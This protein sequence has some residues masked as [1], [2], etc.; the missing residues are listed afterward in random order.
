M[1]RR[2]E[3]IE[4]DR[5]ASGLIRAVQALTAWMKGVDSQARRLSPGDLEVVKLPNVKR[6]RAL[7]EAAQSALETVRSK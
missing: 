6:L 3:L 5:S 2:N 1:R 7:C 4:L